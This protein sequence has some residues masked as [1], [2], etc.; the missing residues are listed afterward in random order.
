VLYLAALILSARTAG[1]IRRR[2]RAAGIRQL[3]HMAYCLR[4]SLVIFVVS[5][6]FTSMAYQWHFPLL[7]G[8]AFGL[9]EAARQEDLA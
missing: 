9:R 7:A 5:A 3:E 8:L 1:R 4:L 6:I 2:A